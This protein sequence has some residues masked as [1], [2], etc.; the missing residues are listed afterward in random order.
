MESDRLQEK[1]GLIG[2]I[3]FDLITTRTLYEYNFGVLL[4]SSYYIAQG[5]KPRLITDTSY[6]NL[7]KYS[8][9]YIFKDFK[10]RIC[11]I[12]IID[13]YYSLPAEEYGEGFP[14]KPLLPDLPD[15]I[16]TQIKTDIYEP[17]LFY[18]KNGGKQFEIDKRWRSRYEPTKI[19]F[20]HDGEILVR[21][22]SI[23]TYM[24][25]YDD[26][27]LFFTTEKGKQK[28]EELSKRGK[29]KF[30]KSICVSRIPPEKLDWLFKESNIVDFKLNLNARE[31]DIYWKE[32]YNWLLTAEGIGDIRIKVLTQEGV[33]SLNKEGGEIRGSYRQYER[34]ER[35]T[36]KT[37]QI[38]DIPAGFERVGPDR[39][40]RK[41]KRHRK[42]L[43]ENPRRQFTP[44]NME[45]RRKFYTS[46]P[47][48]RREET[49]RW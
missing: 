12:N 14:D 23:K 38:F 32:F 33:K 44:T 25:I 22:N 39:T 18:I 13:N 4:V 8:K 17:L 15:L 7:S 5:I 27:L 35:R 24:L 21:D 30:V 29:I 16:Y 3:D 28:M 10:T 20:E 31:D 41:H 40:S 49:R 36:I 9:I 2:I 45:E 46:R 1:N 11:P 34:N 19:F 42:E 37:T 48:R 43:S 6:N 47:G 26:P